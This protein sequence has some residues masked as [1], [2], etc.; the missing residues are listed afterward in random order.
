MHDG[1]IFSQITIC[2]LLLI[3]SIAHASIVLLPQHTANTNMK[4]IVA[5]KQSL[6]L[7]LDKVKRDLRKLYQNYQQQYPNY[8]KKIEAFNQPGCLGG[9]YTELAVSLRQHRLSIVAMKKADSKPF[10]FEKS[11]LKLIQHKLMLKLTG[12]WRDYLKFRQNLLHSS[13]LVRVATEEI[14]ARKNIAG[15]KANL[16]IDIF[17]FETERERV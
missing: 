2:A 8:Q 1:F 17:S 3:I 13:C 12:S 14:L 6:F 7:K 4:N 10:Q 5:E 15:V 9:T 16:L 11:D